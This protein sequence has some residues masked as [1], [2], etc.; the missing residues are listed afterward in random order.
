MITS[1]YPSAIICG[2]VN[3]YSLFKIILMILPPNAAVPS[4]AIYPLKFFPWQIIDIFTLN[5][6]SFL[7]SLQILI[8]F[9]MQYNLFRFYKR[10]YYLHRFQT[11]RINNK[12]FALAQAETDRSDESLKS[13]IFHSSIIYLRERFCLIQLH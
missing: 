6:F 4:E 1:K 10:L 9:S 5:M 8:I 7:S 2:Y 13:S 3:L 12:A 11:R